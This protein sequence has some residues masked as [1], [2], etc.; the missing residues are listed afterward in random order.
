M[1]VQGFLIAVPEGNK[2][3]YRDLAARAAEKFAEYGVTEIMEAWEE[4]VSDGKLTD[5]R[6]ATQAEDGERIVFSWMIWPDKQTCDAAHQRM[7][8]DEFWSQDME[9]PFD[10]MRMIWGGFS[11]LFTMGRD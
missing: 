3:A 2:D 11:P 4:D 7:Q 1:Y 5:F 10:G 9:M 8:D 6:K